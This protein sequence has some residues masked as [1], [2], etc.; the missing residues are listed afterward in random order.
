MTGDLARKLDGQKKQ[1]RTQ[2]LKEAAH[3]NRAQREVDAAAE[4]RNYN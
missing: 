1:T 4:A 2:T 3:E